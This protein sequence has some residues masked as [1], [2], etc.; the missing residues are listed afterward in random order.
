MKRQQ[1]G[2]TLIELITVV[3]ILGVLAAFAI[4]RFASLETEARIGAVK[5]LAGSVRSGAALA[6]AKWMAAGNS[7]STITMEGSSSVAI[8]T[9]YPT[10][11]ITG[12]DATLQDV[13]GFTAS[14]TGPRIWS[15]DGAP[16]PANCSVSY[17]ASVAGAAPAIAITTSGC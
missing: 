10:A 17:T 9:G 3:V 15:L 11:A 8:S 12:I 4:P 16:T 6:H 5:G 2:F 7:P 14:G 13:S 1:S